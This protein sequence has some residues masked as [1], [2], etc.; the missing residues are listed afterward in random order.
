M[1]FW[2]RCY[3]AGDD[4]WYYF[5]VGPDGWVTRQVELLGPDKSPVVAASLDEWTAAEQAGTLADYEA[6]FGATADVAV[7]DW[8]GYEPEDISA[9]EFETVWAM[10]RT[11]CQA[12]GPR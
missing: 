12:R 7:E 10:A 4:T 3:W 9:E 6:T 5:E 8:E 2:F 1:I 11:A